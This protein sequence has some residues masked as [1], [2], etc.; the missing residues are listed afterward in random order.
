M[1]LLN[2]DLYLCLNK[3]HRYYPEKGGVLNSHTISVWRP[4]HDLSCRSV[5]FMNLVFCVWCTDV[6]FGI[7][8]FEDIQVPRLSVYYTGCAPMPGQPSFHSPRK[9]LVCPQLMKGRKWSWI[10][11]SNKEQKL[12]ILDIGLQFW[13]ML[14]KKQVKQ[15]SLCKV[16]NALEN[17][18][19]GICLSDTFVQAQLKIR[20]SHSLLVTSRDQFFS[21][22]CLVAFTSELSIFHSR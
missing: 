12:Q 7:T 4:I 9:Y 21:F 20:I 1:M 22:L 10:S 16:D 18:S 8:Q 13:Q 17:L 2:S 19:K 5:S 6:P 3:L 15:F 11:V 14:L